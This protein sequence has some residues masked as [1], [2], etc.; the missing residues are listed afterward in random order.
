MIRLAIGVVGGGS[1]A[2][3][4]GVGNLQ[5]E[6]GGAGRLLS[7]G[8]QSGVAFAAS[9]QARGC[10]VTIILMG[11]VAVAFI[12]GMIWLVMRIYRASNQ[13]IERRREAWRAGGC[14][15]PEPG[16]VSAPEREWWEGEC[17]GGISGGG[18]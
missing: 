16:K 9:E 2:R 5:R 7:G 1:E 15:G 14:V 17:V 10:V 6:W 11:V 12:A 3:Y 8:G 13:R 18:Y 4:K